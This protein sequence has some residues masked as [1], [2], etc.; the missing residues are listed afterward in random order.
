MLLAAFL[1]QS[2]GPMG[3]VWAV[4]QV[5]LSETCAWQG[6]RACKIMGGGLR[7]KHATIGGYHPRNVTPS[8]CHTS[9]GYLILSCHG[10]QYH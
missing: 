2:G 10:N 5:L 9:S 8:S 6:G 1:L 7:Q 4:P 3:C